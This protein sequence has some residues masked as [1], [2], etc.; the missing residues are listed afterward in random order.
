MRLARII[1]RTLAAVVLAVMLTA[2]GTTQLQEATVAYVD[3]PEGTAE[4]QESWDIDTA[5]D[6]PFH[7]DEDAAATDAGE[8]SAHN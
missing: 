5:S 4:A 2:C 3:T 8:E 6:T 1:T 7:D